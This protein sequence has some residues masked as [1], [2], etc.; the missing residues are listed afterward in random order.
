[1]PRASHPALRRLGSLVAS[2]SLAPTLMLGGAAIGGSAL[3][4]TAADPSGCSLGPNGAVKHVVYVQFDN[5]HFRRDTPNVPSDLE[6]MPNL[7][8]FMKDNGPLLTN[9]HT[10]LISHTAG[11]IL[12]S[13]TGVYPDRHGQVVSNSNVRFNGSGFQFPSSFG[14]WT[15]PVV[16]NAPTVPNMITPDGKNAPAPW[17]PYTPAGCDFGAVA[18]ANTVLENTGTS[19]SGDMT[20]VFG[21]GSPQWNEAEAARLLPNTPANAKAKA[22]PQADFRG[23]A[24][25]CALGSATCATG[26]A[27][28]LPDEPGGYAG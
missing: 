12:S 2:S 27:D 17:V 10:I 21:T 25:P 18:T 13:L 6:Q 15:D 9:D 11:G 23:Y 1:M 14:Y 20:K 16:A 4:K 24:I 22:Q 3:A 28:I 5:P 8:N 26:Q 7:L 19:A